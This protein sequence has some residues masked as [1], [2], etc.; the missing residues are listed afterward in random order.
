[1]RPISELTPSG[2]AGFASRRSAVSASVV[3]L[4]I[5]APVARRLRPRKLVVPDAGPRPLLMLETP[6]ATIGSDR[7]V[8]F[9]TFVP[10]PRCLRGYSNLSHCLRPVEGDVFH[11][12]IRDH[13]APL[14]FPSPLLAC[15]IGLATQ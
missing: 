15:R 14:A 5:C 13:R 11:E 2:S 3:F 9:G 10:P 12:P 8:F 4:V 6:L 7:G 1:L